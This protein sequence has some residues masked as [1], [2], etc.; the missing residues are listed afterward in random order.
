MSLLVLLEGSPVDDAGEG[1]Y[2]QRIAEA[3]AETTRMQ[4]EIARL[5][6]QQFEFVR[7]VPQRPSEHTARQPASHRGPTNPLHQTWRGFV[8][9]MQRLEAYARREGLKLT[10]ANVCRFGVDTVKTIT[11]TM[12]W[13]GLDDH[14]WPPSTWDPTEVREGGKNS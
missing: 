14:D 1:A 6:Q 10:K 4:Q 9:D 2:L 11:R 12:E 5:V 3:L 8:E 13:Y 7:G